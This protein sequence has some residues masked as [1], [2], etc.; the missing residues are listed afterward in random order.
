MRLVA[1]RILT[2]LEPALTAHGIAHDVLVFPNS[3]HALNRDKAMN[4]ELGRKI[5]HYLETYAPLG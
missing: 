3:G 4:E 5:T 2:G 1:M